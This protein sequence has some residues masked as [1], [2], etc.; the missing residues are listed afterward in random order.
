M[1][2]CLQTPTTW[3]DQA[4]DP[5]DPWPTVVAAAVVVAVPVT[6]V[7]L[8]IVVGAASAVAAVV[9]ASPLPGCPPRGEERDLV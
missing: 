5:A 9:S 1:A 8:V 7:A 4:H 6:A 2:G 3:P